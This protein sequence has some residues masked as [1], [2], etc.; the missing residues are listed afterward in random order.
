MVHLGLHRR[1]LRKDLLQQQWLN[2]LLNL[3]RIPQM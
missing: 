3:D 2:V 1:S